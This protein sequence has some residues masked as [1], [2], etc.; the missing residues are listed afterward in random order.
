MILDN[1]GSIELVFPDGRGKPGDRNIE[2]LIRY[3]A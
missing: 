1:A 2:N 3:E